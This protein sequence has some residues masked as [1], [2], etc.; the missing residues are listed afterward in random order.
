MSVYQLKD[1]RW[2]VSWR[3]KDNP[4]KWK[5]KYFGRGVD[6]EAK[7]R[8]YDTELH[9]RPRKKKVKDTS[10]YLSALVNDYAEAK[11]GHV[12]D[13]TFDNLMWKMNGVILPTLGEVR[14]NSI[15]PKKIDAYVKARLNTKTKRGGMVKRTPVHRELSD[16]RAVLNWAVER[17]LIAFNPIEKYKLPKRDDDIIQY[18][19]ADEIAG[20]LQHAPEHQKRA[21]STSY[22]RG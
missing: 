2:V 19:T 13:S 22:Y 21:I 14:A 15:I 9:P 8:E 5:K 16:V 6:E 17:R 10:P 4:G 3:D 1:G 11:Y 18:P 12:Q 7:A 20:I